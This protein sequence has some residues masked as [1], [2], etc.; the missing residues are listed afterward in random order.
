M[1]IQMEIRPLHKDDF[2]DYF[3]DDLRRNGIE[4]NSTNRQSLHLGG[5]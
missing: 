5:H 4:F 3:V 2:E 1:S